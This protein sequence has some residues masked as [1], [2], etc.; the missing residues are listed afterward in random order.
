[1]LGSNKFFSSILIIT[2]LLLS[3]ISCSKS[4]KLGIH[5]LPD[6]FI[7]REKVI[8][9]FYM[10]DSSL[11]VDETSVKNWDK[12]LTDKFSFYDGGNYVIHTEKV[13]FDKFSV[14][15]PDF[16]YQMNLEIPAERFKKGAKVD[17]SDIKGFIVWGGHNSIYRED[18]SPL[19]SGVVK[20]Q[21]LDDTK[22]LYAWVNLYFKDRKTG[23][24]I[25]IF[26]KLKAPM[27]TR[28]QYQS[29]EAGVKGK[30]Y[31]DAHSL[32]KEA[33]SPKYFKR[34]SKF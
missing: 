33:W 6:R 1:M 30:I 26:G 3:L 20:I 13:H 12:R 7:E 22:K 8:E 17:A 29:E 15:E 23:E 28:S 18:F 31:D 24:F 2:I 5:G 9:A 19:V 32:S 16:Q 10:P 25:R 34:M 21:N 4:S 14:I 11:V 27:K